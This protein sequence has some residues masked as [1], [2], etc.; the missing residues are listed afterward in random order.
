MNSECIICQL[1]SIRRHLETVSIDESQR[2]DIIQSF[3]TY[4]GSVDRKVSNPE[5]AAELN[6]LIGVYHSEKSIYHNEKQE[7][8]QYMLQ[9]YDHYLQL[10][11]N[12][13]DPLKTA[14]KLAIAGNII[15]FGPEHSFSVDDTIQR[16]LKSELYIDDSEALFREIN[17]AKKILYLGDNAGEIVMDKLFIQTMQRPDVQFATRGFPVLNDVVSEDAEQ[18]KMHEVCTVIDNGTDIPST[19]LKKC[20]PEFVESFEKADLIISK[21]Q[22]NLEGLLY[23]R[24][25]NIFFLFTVKC[26]VIAK[27]TNTKKGDFVL[28][29]ASKL[30]KGYNLL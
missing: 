15:D 22:G 5:M 13:T 24:H 6:R 28:M 12:S 8:N 23:E 14:V 16:V 10:A 7:F 17:S 26:D 29:H 25:R 30:P 11:Q 9:L 3:L 20:S 2:L 21:G 1:K 18:V 19:V 27:L 4:L